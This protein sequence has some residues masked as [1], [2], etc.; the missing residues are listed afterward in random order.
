[1]SSHHP[2]PGHSMAI[3][4][5][6]KKMQW[7]QTVSKVSSRGNIASQQSKSDKKVSQFA[8]KVSKV[9]L[10]SVKAKAEA[11]VF[12]QRIEG[13]GSWVCGFEKRNG[14]ELIPETAE[15][16]VAVAVDPYALGTVKGILHTHRFGNAPVAVCIECSKE[17][18]TCGEETVAVVVQPKPIRWAFYHESCLDEMAKRDV[19]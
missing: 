19:A 9:S 16:E 13:G 15:S 1:M 6:E 18:L 4:A 12:D 10:Q 7:E 14:M 3:K 11:V 17:L 8:S 5:E 2:C